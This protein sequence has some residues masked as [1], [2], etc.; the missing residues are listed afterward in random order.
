M[1]R[2]TLHGAANSRC[3]PA[4]VRGARI[5]T[6]PKQR[7]TLKEVRRPARVR[8]ARIETAT[9]AAE[10]CRAPVAP[11]ACAGRGLKR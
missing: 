2:L 9:S 4:R 6:M 3:R 11:R 1:K 8:G 10:P 7:K 5:E